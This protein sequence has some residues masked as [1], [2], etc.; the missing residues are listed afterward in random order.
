MYPTPTL[1][2]FRGTRKTIGDYIIETP[3]FQWASNS[4]EEKLGKGTEVFLK[5]ELFQ[6]SGTFKA[7]GAL[8]NIA[9][10]SDSEKQMGV[11]AVSAG[12]HAI[13]VAYAANALRV[14]AKV[15]MQNTASSARI[16]AAQK[17]GAEVILEVPGAPAFE[18]ANKISQEEGRTFVHPFDGLHTILGTGTLGLEIADTIQDLD[19]V[20]VSIGGGG[21]AA[22]M[23]TAIKHIQPNC[24]IY[25]VEPEGADVMSRSFEKN[26][27]QSM[28]T[29]KTIADSLAPPMT[30][31]LP[32]ELCHRA[33]ERII[34]VS[35]QQLCEA[36]Y[37]LFSE[38]KLA[39]EPA[40]AAATAALLGEL[41]DELRGKRVGVII[42]GAN[43]DLQSFYD[44]AKRGAS[45]AIA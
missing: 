11:T 23:A 15:V 39:V 5:L 36:M 13:A 44:H 27:A 26:A 16:E 10:L 29:S 38:M 6:H 14:S 22:G 7:R 32:Y 41:A 9:A 34:T 2:Q 18:A 1:E 31:P 20:I 12:N 35:D 43:I 25:G 4:I 30:M 3:N 33:I 28:D 19:A 45:A 17:F 21:L 37:L 40:A 8:A 42:C 24:R